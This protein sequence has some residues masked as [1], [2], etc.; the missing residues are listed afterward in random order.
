MPIPEIRYQRRE[1]LVDLPGREP[2]GG[3]AV[4]DLIRP[5]LELD[6]ASE[7]RVRIGMHF[8]KRGEKIPHVFDDEIVRQN[9]LGKGVTDGTADRGDQQ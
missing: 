4:Q 3:N 8:L 7:C 5:A 9:V 6:L 2:G 1:V